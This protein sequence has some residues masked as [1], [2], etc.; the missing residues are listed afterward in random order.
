MTIQIAL[1]LLI[2]IA[3]IILFSFEWVAVDI[4]ALGILLALILTGL[5]PPDKAFA[6]F[7]SD[8][9]ML[10]LGLLILTATLVRTG[11]VELVGRTLQS[12]TGTQP[13]RMLA[14]IMVASAGLSSF[15]SNTA[16]TAFYIPVVTGLARRSRVSISRLLL[17][18]AFASILASSVTLIGT[19]TNVV[20]SGL[21]TQY[22]M[23]PLGMFELTVVGLPIVV[24]GILYM[25]F[26]GKKLIPERAAPEELTEEFNLLPF[27]TEILI[28]PNSSL[29]GKTLSESGLGRDLGLTV[30]RIRRGDDSRLIPHADFQLETG[31]ALLVEGHRD[32]LLRMKTAAHIGVE[33]DQAL[34]DLDLQGDDLRLAEVILLPRSPLIGRQLYNLGLR[35]QY[36]VQ[37]LAIN[38]HEETIHSQISQAVLRMGDVLLVHGPQASLISL[39][40][41][42]TYR[43]LN[44]V[45]DRVPNPKSARLALLIFIGAISLAALNV[46]SLPVAVLLG[47][48]LAF[49]TR[50]ITPQEAYNDVE[51]RL[52]III[53]CMLA[54]G[55]AME[56]TGTASYLASGIVNLVGQAHP[57]W[58]LSGFFLLTVMLTQPMSNQAAAVV[59]FPV[60]IQTAL[61]LGLNPRAFAVMIAVAAS[62]SFITPLEPACLLVY[63]L[64]RYRF[65]DFIRVGSL[66]TILVYLVAILLVPL[67]WPL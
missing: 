10:I 4:V 32:N 54:F 43:I 61:Q 36:G 9:A 38:R 58:L 52:I 48:L 50:C 59:V 13:D 17:P 62:T 64:G 20:V 37:V 46:V 1:L 35:E 5:L 33:A 8:T 55:A 19:S 23:P 53:G 45:E 60:A 12:R 56:Y 27:L 6:G 40:R 22:G 2:L 66:L 24:V 65:L 7:G 3:T 31:D 42:N 26:L 14:M 63:G 28:L 57:A 15:I 30:I 51:W 39:E 25:F 11:V 44:T 49:L 18:L 34:S 41:D 47:S 16:A 21:M 67:F 29:V